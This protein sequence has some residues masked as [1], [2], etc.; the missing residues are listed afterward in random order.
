MYRHIAQQSPRWRVAVAPGAEGALA[1]Y[2][3]LSGM[4][5]GFD[6]DRVQTILSFGAPVLHGWSTPG[7]LLARRTEYQLIQIEPSQSR[8]AA[9]A[10]N[11][12]PIKPGAENAFALGV[13]NIL[14]N[15]GLTPEPRAT[16]WP[17]YRAQLALMPPEQAAALS[18]VSAGR[19]VE[20]ARAFAAGP[21]IALGDSVAIA[22]LN[23]L[24][25]KNAA[26]L[27]RGPAPSDTYFDSVPD[28]SIDVLLA[29]IQT[30]LPPAMIRR[31][32]SARGVL[33]AF[34][35]YATDLQA[36]ADIVIPAP[37]WLEM[38]EDVP[39][40]PDA[41]VESLS[42]SEAVLP[43][44]EGA[45]APADVIAI[46]A[47]VNETLASQIAAKIQATH[48]LRRGTLWKYSDGSSLPAAEVKAEDFAAALVEGACWTDEP[49]DK[50]PKSVRMLAGLS[51]QE[52]ARQAASIPDDATMLAVEASVA[53]VPM[54]GKLYRES[55]LFAR[56]DVA[57]INPA[58]AVEQGLSQDKPVLVTTRCGSGNPTVRFDA[59]VGPGLVQITAMPPAGGKGTAIRLCEDL[60]PSRVELRRA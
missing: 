24:I 7:R 37:C 39:G 33:I 52:F 5:A 50:R 2:A 15:E 35:P 42:L 25:G 29:D 43:P 8:T 60:K 58:T 13:A 57:R 51:S 28:A 30:A 47:G 41:P 54:L 11:W 26:F 6:Y 36:A 56:A 4:A 22:G 10:N 3:K 34:S 44:R 32:L 55:N 45:V 48:S 20:V 31:K 49:A 40:P 27:H 59:A 18:G 9:F 46:L 21:S 12:I 53:P 17:A 19:I 38:Q 23:I 16:D 14:V 1:Q